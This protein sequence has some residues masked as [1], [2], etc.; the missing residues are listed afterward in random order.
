MHAMAG[1]R[2][3]LIRQ[4]VPPCLLQDLL[5]HTQI[6]CF[7]LHSRH[8]VPGKQSNSWPCSR[9]TKSLMSYGT[10]LPFPSF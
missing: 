3:A 8:C 2:K 1:F 9:N 5:G 6:S 10:L 7:D 4:I